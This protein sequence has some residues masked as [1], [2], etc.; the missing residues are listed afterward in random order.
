MDLVAPQKLPSIIVRG[1]ATTVSLPL[2]NATDYNTVV[3]PTS[4]TFTLKD[5]AGTTTVSAAAVTITDGIP[6]Y[7]VTTAADATLSRYWL[8]TWSVVVAGATYSFSRTAVVAL[9]IPRPV[10]TRDDLIKGRNLWMQK[11]LTPALI[12]DYLAAAWDDVMRDLMTAD[13]DPWRNLTPSALYHPHMHRAE[14]LVYKDA[15]A[16]YE[17][18]T[19]QALKDYEESR[20]KLILVT[21]N[22][23]DGLPSST[24]KEYVLAA[25]TVTRSRRWAR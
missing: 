20:Q 21:D 3:V 5:P 25:G 14:F 11:T 17:S 24:E 19:G 7:T 22:D 10:V 12:E 16:A 9:F 8:E 18:R 15:G 23:D 1:V 2:R 6:T 4:G 13:R